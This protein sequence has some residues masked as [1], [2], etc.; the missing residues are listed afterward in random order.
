[1]LSCRVAQ[2]RSQT[3]STLTEGLGMRLRV[4]MILRPSYAYLSAL[5]GALLEIT[6][7]INQFLFLKM[8]DLAGDPYHAA[9]AVWKF[10]G[11]RPVKR[12]SVLLHLQTRSNEMSWIKSKEYRTKFRML[13][14][15]AEL[16]QS[17][18]RPYNNRL[19]RLLKDER[20]LW[21]KNYVRN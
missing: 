9:A 21:Q 20:F 2:S 13:P 15:T 19:A 7:P 1:M 8:E 11:L 6:G 16:L 5:F 4:S 12:K 3:L 10:L 14:E 17:F 18:Y